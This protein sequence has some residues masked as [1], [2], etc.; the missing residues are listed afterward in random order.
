MFSKFLKKFLYLLIFGL[1]LPTSIKAGID[2]EIF[3]KCINQKDFDSCVE[4]SSKELLKKKKYLENAKNEKLLI[5]KA[6]AAAQKEELEKSQELLKKKKYLEKNSIQKVPTV[7]IPS[8]DN[9]LSPED[10]FDKGRDEWD[11]NN[12]IYAEKLYTLL[13]NEK[14]EDEFFYRGYLSRGMLRFEQNLRDIKKAKEDLNY[15]L[16]NYCFKKGADKNQC[17][18]ALLI[19]ANLNEELNDLDGSLMDLNKVIKKDRYWDLPYQDRAR[20]YF[21]LGND[22]KFLADTKKVIKYFNDGIRYNWCD[23][24]KNCLNEYKE[25]LKDTY[26]L[27]A[28][29]FYKIDDDKKGQLYLKKAAKLNPFVNRLDKAS[30]MDQSSTDGL[31]IWKKIFQ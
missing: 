18:W 6:K 9:F 1:I 4:T 21:K 16:K 26:I 12:Y 13:L 25:A 28:K 17:N 20:V 11:K 10:L 29:Y 19:R 5:K 14:K 27:K 23:N 24:D 2:P 3:N 31:K 30:L 15:G 22:K 8:S 7:D